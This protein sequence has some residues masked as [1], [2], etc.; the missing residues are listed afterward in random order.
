MRKM[1]SNTLH[2]MAAPH[3][4][5]F[6]QPSRCCFSSRMDGSKVAACISP[7]KTLFQF[8]YLMILLGRHPLAPK[9]DRFLRDCR[10]LFLPLLMK[11]KSI[12][13]NQKRNLRLLSCGL[14]WN[15]GNKCLRDIVDLFEEEG[16]DSMNWTPAKTWI[17][18]DKDRNY[19]YLCQYYVVIHLQ[20]LD[21]SRKFIERI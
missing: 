10:C 6:S 9:V 4:L 15:K 20:N 8:L 21:K 3:M 19:Q 11:I 13:F 14:P 2:I 17:S 12:R 5:G 16:D 18:K 7:K 1:V